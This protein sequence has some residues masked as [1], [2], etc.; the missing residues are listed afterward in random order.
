MASGTILCP[1]NCI[2]GSKV[3]VSVSVSTAGMQ[4][5]DKSELSSPPTRSGYTFVEWLCR[6]AS[7]RVVPI[8]VA[9]GTRL[10]YYVGTTYSSDINIECYPLYMRD[11]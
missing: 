8:G 4:A 6:A 7:Y 3:T 11:A 10:Y 5:V 2:L 9:G 1:A